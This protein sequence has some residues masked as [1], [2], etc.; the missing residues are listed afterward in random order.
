M[1]FDLGDDKTL[2]RVGQDLRGAKLKRKK[3]KMSVHETMTIPVKFIQPDEIKDDAVMLGYE[4]QTFQR[5]KLNDRSFEIALLLG[6]RFHYYFMFF[7][8]LFLSGVSQII[9]GFPK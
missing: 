3:I 2:T 7:V 9:F 8:S 1:Q 4:P 5:P 6:L